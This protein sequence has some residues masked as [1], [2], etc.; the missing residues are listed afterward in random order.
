M[1]EYLRGDLVALS[2]DSAVI[3]TG[4][5]GYRLKVP[6]SSVLVLERQERGEVQLY[7]LCRLR[8]EQFIIY[9][10]AT[11]TRRQSRRHKQQ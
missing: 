3:E 4:G 11:T 5:I 8:D 6:A 1:Y 7:T 2:Q 9:G 10:F